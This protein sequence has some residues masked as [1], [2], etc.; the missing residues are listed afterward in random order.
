MADPN[1]QKKE[2]V[3][4]DLPPLPQP[5][6]AEPPDPS[7]KSRE[8]VRIHLPNRQ[9]SVPLQAPTG[10]PLVSTPIDQ[11]LLSPQFFQPPPPSS[12]LPPPKQPTVTVPRPAPAPVPVTPASTLPS[13]VPTN[14]T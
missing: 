8:T 13:P 14:E 9:L 10:P 7:T 6:V 2:T 3:R 5:S 12:P 4:I 1:D 11:D